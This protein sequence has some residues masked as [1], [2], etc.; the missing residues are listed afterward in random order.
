M[1]E[2]ECCNKTLLKFLTRKQY[3]FENKSISLCMQTLTKQSKF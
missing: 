2:I 3:T 1:S